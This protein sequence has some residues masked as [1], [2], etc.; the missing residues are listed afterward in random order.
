MNPQRYHDLTYLGL[1]RHIRDY[2]RH[3]EDRT[4][5][6]TTAVFGYD[7]RFNI[8]NGVIPL[9]TTKKM[10]LPA[11]LHEIVWYLSGDTNIQ[12]LQD[13]G[14][15]IWNEWAD[16]NGELG[17]VYGNQWRYW[18]GDVQHV[19]YSDPY[20]DGKVVGCDDTGAFIQPYIDQIE[21]AINTLKTN[22]DSRRII[23]SCWNVAQIAD[24]KLPPCHA[25]FQL[26]AE[27]MDV[28][29]RIEWVKEN[30]DYHFA[31]DA[32]TNKLL[33]SLGAPT[34]FL[35]CKL[36]QRS[37]DAF[38]GVPFNIA[39][40]SMLTCIL[41]KVVGMAP[42]D[43]IWSGG[44]CHIYD[45]HKDQVAEQLSRTPYPSPKFVLKDFVDNIDELKYNNMSVEGYQSHG[46]IK[47]AVA[48]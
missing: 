18:P 39:Q 7:M 8:R 4:G 11:I 40:Y 2:G 9:L 23:I 28:N 34:R 46:T 41:A 29:E 32:I 45:N 33:D 1:L 12:Y 27:E 3:K 35:S 17:P 19:M 30:T 14:V 16:A 44:D 10:H 5:T 37:A 6:G 31:S 38:L 26:Y 21:L 25:F 15:R 48:V 22:P 20:P 13:N 43:F 24:M 47:A 36:T 42:K